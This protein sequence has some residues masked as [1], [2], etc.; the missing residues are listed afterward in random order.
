MHKVADSYTTNPQAEVLVLDH[1]GPEYILGVVFGRS[2]RVTEYARKF[3]RRY[4]FEVRAPFF[5]PRR[6]YANW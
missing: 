5:G 3:G 6:D 4:H 1:I 2:E